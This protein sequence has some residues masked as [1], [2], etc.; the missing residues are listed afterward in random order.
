ME[1]TCLDRGLKMG[2]CC[3]SV[4][5]LHCERQP[6]GPRECCVSPVGEVANP[7]QMECGLM[8]L[9]SEVQ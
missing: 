7:S 6:T 2:L 9:M 8:G 5:M 4:K 3:L 1:R